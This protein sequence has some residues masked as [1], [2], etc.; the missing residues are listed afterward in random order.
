[1]ILCSANLEDL[2]AYEFLRLGPNCA[3][4]SCQ[5][6]ITSHPRRPVVVAPQTGNYMLIYL[7]SLLFFFSLH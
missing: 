7:Y 3:N 6:P 4:A 2:I 1:M 5:L